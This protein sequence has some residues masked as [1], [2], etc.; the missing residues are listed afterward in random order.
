MP[1]GKPGRISGTGYS[2]TLPGLGSSLPRNCS[3]KFE[4]HTA[5]AG[6][7]TTSCGSMVF[8]GRSYSVM[9]TRV[10]APVGRGS[11]LSE[12]DHTGPELRLTP[13]RSYPTAR[14][15][16]AYRPGATFVDG[17]L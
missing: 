1:V 5:P 8:R 6:S 7:T 4:N 11:V 3:P 16:M 14:I 9:M 17:K 13:S 15:L 2:V 12:Y 10:D